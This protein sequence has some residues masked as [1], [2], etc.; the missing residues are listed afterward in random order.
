M[1]K[2]RSKTTRKKT[3]PARRRKATP[4]RKAKS[5]RAKKTA[6]RQKTARVS[7]KRVRAVPTGFNTVSAHLTVS[8]GQE[9]LAFYERAFG[10]TVTNRMIGPD[11]SFLHGEVQ[12]GNSSVMVGEE[13]LGSSKSPRSLGGTP[14][15]VH[16]YVKDADD[17][18][19]RAIQAGA[20][21]TRP[22]ENQFWGD[23]YGQLV[24]PF[25]HVWAV[26]THIED[27]SP[28]EMTRRLKAMFGD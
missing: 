9:A 25:G 28:R 20:R 6:P 24:D 3:R 7:K 22:L 18:F 26:A 21:V 2:R 1:A 19:M 17:F 15:T 27:V 10:G 12:V 23:R 5:R 11:G 16:V 13:V 8:E 4:A 14:V